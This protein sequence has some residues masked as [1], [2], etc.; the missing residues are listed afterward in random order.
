[1]CTATPTKSPTPTEPPCP[2][3]RGVG[4][5]CEPPPT[6]PTGTEPAPDEPDDWMSWL[7]AVFAWLAAAV[8]LA[9]MVLGGLL[10]VDSLRS[11]E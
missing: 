9:P 4:S 11:G 10:G 1:M 3:Y 5:M 6:E 7:V 2:D 8:V